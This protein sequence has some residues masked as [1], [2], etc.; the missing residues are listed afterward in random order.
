MDIECE[1]H[2]SPVRIQLRRT[3]GD[4]A[5]C[6]LSRFGRYIS[7]GCGLISGIN[8]RRESRQGNSSPARRT[9]KKRS[10]HAEKRPL[11]V[12][13]LLAARHEFETGE[14]QNKGVSSV[15]KFGCDTHCLSIRNRD[16]DIQPQTDSETLIAL[17]G[18]SN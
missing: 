7:A 2:I 12:R 4:M 13:L 11:Q 10:E 1:F 16:A 3:G 8:N 14:M 5:Q 17:K 18:C 9:E 15:G 6:A